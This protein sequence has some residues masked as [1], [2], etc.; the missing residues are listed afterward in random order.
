M[1][2]LIPEGS[3]VELQKIS[4]D[5]GDQE[6][7]R[8]EG[9]QG[10]ALP[11]VYP[12]QLRNGHHLV[13]FQHAQAFVY[14]GIEDG[15]IQEAC[16]GRGKLALNGM[17]PAVREAKKF[18]PRQE[19]YPIAA[20]QRLPDIIEYPVLLGDRFFQ[21]NRRDLPHR[22]YCK[23]TEITDGAII[24]RP[25]RPGGQRPGDDVPGHGDEL[26]ALAVEFQYAAGIAKIHDA[27]SI[28]DGHPI[29][30]IGLE[31]FRLIVGDDRRTKFRH[32]SG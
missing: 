28:L 20:A 6:P 10:D 3:E 29:L 16:L 31:L 9:C 30:A 26:P 19:I 24:D 8:S 22:R 21:R 15:A 14:V 2:I 18:F 11:V 13:P 1:G 4:R 23:K 5:T 17:H 25:I 32:L 7:L 12:G 27:P